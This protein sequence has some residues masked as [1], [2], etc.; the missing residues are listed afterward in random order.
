MELDILQA[1]LERLF[2][3]SALTDLARDTLGF[4]P[5]AIGGTQALGSFARAL[6]EYC[7]ERQALEALA[8]ALRILRTDASPE[9]D[10]L[11]ARGTENDPALR[12]GDRFFDVQIV[13]QLGEG[14]V[15]RSYVGRTGERQ[16]RLK[17]LRL[18]AAQD[19]GALMRFQVHTRLL[20]RVTDPGLPSGLALLNDGSRVAVV[21]DYVEGQS[22][23]A[24]LARSG[25]LHLNE[26]RPLLRSLLAALSKLH[27]RRLVH[28]DLRPENVLLSRDVDGQPLVV[29]LDAGTDRL[30]SRCIE[31][32]T[33]D[34]LVVRAASIAPELLALEPPTPAS[35]VYAFGALV[36]ELLTGRPP[37]TGSAYEQ[38]AAHLTVAPTPPSQFAPR[39][40]VNRELDEFVLSLLTKDPLERSGSV[41][42]V[43]ARLEALATSA[44]RRVCTLTEEELNERIELLVL[45]PASLE[46]A[47]ALDAAVDEGA[48]PRRIAEAFGIAAAELV[49][50]VSDEAQTARRSLLLR[51][52]R[53]YEQALRDPGAAEPFYASAVALEPGD[54]IA[55][56]SLERV[57]RLQNKFEELIEILLQRGEKAESR[58]ERARSFAEIGRLYVSELGELEQALVAFTQALCEDVQKDSYAEEI[59]RLAGNRA[60]AWA[61]VL[62]ACN[63]PL[64]DPTIPSD[65]KN[66]LL[67]RVGRWYADKVSRPDMALPCFQSVIGTDPSNSAALEALANIYRK[68]QQWPELG[69]VLTRWS[70]AAPTP[71]RARALRTEAAELAEHQLGDPGGART[72]YEA[73]LSEDPGHEKAS[74][75]L[76]RICEAAGDYAGYA[77]VL[78]ARSQALSG[79][80]KATVLVRLAEIHELRLSNDSEAI[81]L[82]E[83]V[84]VAQPELLEALR[85]IDRLYAK[86]G[87]YA[88]LIDVIERQVKLAATPR[89]KIQLLERVAAV[90]E[91]EFFAHENANAAFERI[92]LLDSHHESAVAGLVRNYRALEQ[93]SQ[94]ADLTERQLELV[95]DQAR[96]VNLAIALGRVC[97]D[98]LAS[99]ERAMAAFELVLVH[100]PQNAEALEMLAR[101]RESLG[102]ADAAL[103]A[104]DA[105]AEKATLPEARAEQYLRAAKLLEGRGDF[106]EAIERYKLALDAQPTHTA[107]SA[108]LREAYLSRG[109]PH[110]AAT[111]LEQEINR[112]K[113]E[114]AQGR[115]RGELSS[116]F[117]RKL[118]E[119]GRAEE[120]AR[121]AI[122]LD[123]TNVDALAVLG[124]L[125]FEDGRL[126]E[127][128]KHYGVLVDRIE[129]LPREFITGTLQRAV[130][131][132]VEAGN[133][134]SAEAAAE[135]LER[136]CPNDL[137][138]LLAVGAVLFAKGEPARSVE[139]ADRILAD[140]GDRLRGRDRAIVLYRKGES[141]RR[142]GAN[143]QALASLEESADL[144]PTMAE[145]LVSIAQ[146]FA[147]LERWDDVIRTKNRHLDIADADERVQLLIDIGDVTAEKLGD[148]TRAAKSLVAALDERPDDR[149]LLSKLMQLY[150]EEKDWNRLVEVVLKLAEFVEDPKQKAKYLN[151]AAIVSA[152]QLGDVNT[153]LSYY[154]QVIELDPSLHKALSEAID[155][156]R[157][158]ADH[159]GVERLLHHKLELLRF[160]TD[161]VAH[162][163]TLGELVD[164][165]EKELGWREKAVETLEKL[166]QLEPSNEA[167]LV[168]LA[169]LY[170]SDTDQ[171][172]EQAIE[173]QLAL[174]DLDPFRVDS[175]KAIRRLHAETKN[176]D[177]A[178]CLCQAVTVMKV[179]DPQEEGFYK[180]MRAET[181]APAQA[182]FTEEDWLATTHPLLDPLLTRLFSLI[183]PAVVTARTEPLAKLG[184]ELSDAVDLAAHP[185][186]MAQTLFY[187]GGVLGIPVPPCFGLR[188]DLGGLSFLASSPCAIGLGRVAMS[189]QV[190]PQAAAFIAARHLAYTRPG[191][192]LRQLLPTGTGLKS[193]LFAAIKLISPQFPLA[194]EIEG[195]VNEAYAA[196]D[197]GLKGAERD[198]LTRVV[199]NLLK[200]GTSL[201]LKR[202]AAAVDLSAD[203]VGF[204]IAHDLDTAA[205]LI[206]ASDES[207]SAVPGQERLKALVL[208]SVDPKYQAL[209]HRLGIAVDS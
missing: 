192:Y 10:L 27:E 98:H 109:N 83:S 105:L 178:W 119:A 135:A 181:A 136:L 150:S 172:L 117:L 160:E 173:A 123:P 164:L 149:R 156:R 76:A 80:A 3:L 195:A 162:L 145:P 15:A 196:L 95:D 45:E 32:N 84:L 147:A 207:S 128:A 64:E 143:E 30:R 25:P 205:Q 69:M 124:D 75:G 171:F 56:K 108:A 199:S 144:D 198:E 116:I 50:E 152:R 129:L 96:R 100:E 209:R 44:E 187:A 190:P 163:A 131:A 175:Y 72:L 121:A 94:V 185:A 126:H 168:R 91:E 62:D 155:L 141:L 16:L 188:D 23:A 179:G 85:S 9:L 137:D 60:D 176:A 61:E 111:L 8:D 103:A 63:G 42:G 140:L 154:E 194:T 31:P 127:A 115:L 70:D 157:G 26:A 36:Y 51:T 13:R 34:G 79:D 5:E 180:R 202:W 201:D 104:I 39:G 28:G 101:L 29:L 193:W 120:M 43:L 167:H 107:A 118:H 153:A 68:A 170:A 74:E 46:A 146:V 191:F 33:L 90:H 86:L 49:A 138:A 55:C 66:A 21:H 78:E 48:D 41:H 73:V 203:R 65:V 11:R 130:Q 35:D 99:P 14:R 19:R 102:D 134:T 2:D 87:R 40:W 22:L 184:H 17:V 6:I 174:L 57:L 189:S 139:L 161:R 71:A 182:V 54:D 67:V 20:A 88:D 47:A 148:R 125:A 24:R 159:V 122:N 53:L 81:K 1:E 114:R 18:R 112:T 113:G 82:L 132:L 97:G 92:L 208:F 59:E 7:A 200:D 133:S 4:D 58:T 89:Q 93:W 77:R 169:E 204:V 151:T 186:P 183:E 158:M 177:G 142:T 165:Y 110:A 38:A 166:R 197:R 206:R 12:V 52:A 106:D 37:F